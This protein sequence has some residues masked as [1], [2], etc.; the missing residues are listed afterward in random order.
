MPERKL[1]KASANMQQYM[2]WKSWWGSLK[3]KYLLRSLG[4]PEI[5]GNKSNMLIFCTGPARNHSKEMGQCAAW[6]LESSSGVIWRWA[7][8]RF[9]GGPTERANF[10]QW[11]L[12]RRSVCASGA[13]SDWQR[14]F[15]WG[16]GWMQEQFQGNHFFQEKCEY[17][18]Y[19][20]IYTTT[21]VSDFI[22]V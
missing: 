5:P 16:L 22:S 12:D 14:S 3:V 11:E 18:F 17:T 1:G 13:W 20:S 4:L 15:R 21:C 9:A 7:L 10:K 8:L 19:M 6:M 2:S